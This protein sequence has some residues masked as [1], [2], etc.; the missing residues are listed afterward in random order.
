M[1]VEGRA[2]VEIRYTIAV[3]VYRHKRVFEAMIRG[4][5]RL[6]PAMVDRL[7]FLLEP[8]GRVAETRALIACV[9]HPTDVI[10]N[11]HVF[12]M[13]GNWNQCIKRCQGTHL[14]ILHDDDIL[15]PGALRK[16]SDIIRQHHPAVIGSSTRYRG[17]SLANLIKS[18]ANSVYRDRVYD[19]GQFARFLDDGPLA[20]SGALFDFGVADK[21]EFLF[22]DRFPYSADEELWPRLLKRH[23]I[24]RTGYYV[25]RSYSLGGENY[26]IETWK[27]PDFLHNYFQIR[28]AIIDHA[29]G[30]DHVRQILRCDVERFARNVEQGRHPGIERSYTE[31]LDLYEAV[32]N[33]T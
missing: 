12:G 13:V 8:T 6:E 26:E 17:A 4:L 9:R 25:N 22:S 18:L 16:Y 20:P 23:R 27:E 29:G 15:I 24:V 28:A 11:P 3:P 21:E 5:N 32:I 33:G 10:T 19:P 14:I 1:G 7:L 2:F 31:I 30:D